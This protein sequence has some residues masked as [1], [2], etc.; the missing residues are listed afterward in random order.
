MPGGHAMSMFAIAHKDL[1]Q[2]AKALA[3]VTVIGIAASSFLI[4]STREMKTQNAT[5]GFLIGSLVFGMPIMFSMWLIGQ[6]KAK[7]TIR[8]LKGLPIGGVR[9]MIAKW[10]LAAV[11]TLLATLTVYFALPLFLGAAQQAG[12]IDRLG[13]CVWIVAL[14]MLTSGLF[15]SLFVVLDQKLATQVSWIGMSLLIFTLGRI[16]EMAAVKRFMA[17]GSG[18]HLWQAAQ[19]AGWVIA[20]LGGLVCVVFA[21]R[22]IDQRDI[23]ELQEN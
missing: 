2:N 5:E 7:G 23:G 15:F 12:I 3:L 8:I 19:Q 14:S 6:E 4:F 21:G 13:R 20:A 1:E 10:L 16:A 22:Y 11:F 18:R 17:Q 9:I